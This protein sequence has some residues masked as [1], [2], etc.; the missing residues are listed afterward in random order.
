M[1]ATLKRIED[2]KA[3]GVQQLEVRAHH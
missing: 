3:L 2:Y 1:A